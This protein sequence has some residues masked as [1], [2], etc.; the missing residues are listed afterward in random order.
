MSQSN[1]SL[2]EQ[3]DTYRAESASKVPANPEM[4]AVYAKMLAQLVQNE[5]V[6][7]TVQAGAQAPDFSLPNVDGNLL[8]LSELLQLGPVVVVFYRGDWCPFCNLTLRAYQ[9]IFPQ[10]QAAGASMVA[11]SPQTPDYSI[12]TV[13]H[14]ELTFPVLSD[15]GNATARRYGLVYT[16]PEEV[17]AYSPNLVQFNGTDSWELPM[18]GTF[19]ISRSGE[20]SLAF[21]SPYPTQRL[22]PSAILTEL[23][24]LRVTN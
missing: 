20:V 7:H 24:K 16:L 15:V 13:E 10:I 9:R 6:K 14:K 11:I 17:R 12:L 2:Q 4:S 22:E 23:D 19:V 1:M 3:I 21:A 18:P 5:A 8:T